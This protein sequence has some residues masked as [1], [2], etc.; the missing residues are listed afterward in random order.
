MRCFLALWLVLV[1]AVSISPLSFK[2]K[3]HTMG[4]LHNFGHYCIYALTAVF[5]W[6]TV[7]RWQSRCFGFV[8]GVTLSLFQEW[9]EN[10][11]YRAGFEWKDVRIDFVGLVSGFALM[12]FI[13]AVMADGAAEPRERF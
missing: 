10:K 6:L 2:L 13:M 8:F 7:K 5:L 3:L 4:A 1:M 11:L 9:L 12:L